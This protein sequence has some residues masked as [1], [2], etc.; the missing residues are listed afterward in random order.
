MEALPQALLEEI[1]KRISRLIDLNSLSLVSK[2]FYTVESENRHSIRV[3]CGL[4]PAELA[5][6]SLCLRIPNLCTVEINYSGWTAENGLQL[7]NQG[8][9]VLATCCPSLTDLTLS[10]CSNINDYGLCWIAH[11][12][13]LTCLKLNTV[14]AISSAGLF[15]VAVGCKSLSALR[16]IGLEKVANVNW[17]EYLGREG[18]LEELVVVACK[19]ISQYEVLRFG[20]GWMK[21]QRFEFDEVKG[22]YEIEQPHDPSHM[23]H[24]HCRYDFCCQ[25]LKVLTLARVVTLPEIGLRFF[26][27]N[28]KSLEKLCLHYVV[29]IYD[30]DMITLSRSCSNLRSLSLQLTPLCNGG[31]EARDVRTPLTDDSLKALALSCPLLETVELTFAACEPSYPSEIGFTQNGFVMLIQSCPICDLILTGANF[32]NDEGMKALSSTQYLET[33][34]LMDCV[35]ISDVGMRFLAHSPR[36]IN[37]TLRQCHYVSDR[38]LT[39]VA[40]S[41]SLESLI[42][43]G[44]RR[45]SLEAIQGAAKS[46]EYKVDGPGLFCLNRG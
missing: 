38:A 22:R 27:N 35:A 10:Y 28:C 9:S 46:V 20:P 11:C 45:V 36:L 34:E 8:L 2:L 26:L 42:V 3:G 21:P 44:C 6:A 7:D 25:S 40:R 14:P 4:Y 31:L 30:S 33:L 1:V 13:K 5:M 43:E 16:L 19:G 23:A 12:K 39:E 15:T 41:R 32:F 24:S 29:G 17:L 37:L 18:L